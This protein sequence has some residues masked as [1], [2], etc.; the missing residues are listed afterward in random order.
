[1]GS[2]KGARGLGPALLGDATPVR[3]NTGMGVP[4][5]RM[6]PTMKIS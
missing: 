5:D 1:M 2:G 3:E 6:P 4:I